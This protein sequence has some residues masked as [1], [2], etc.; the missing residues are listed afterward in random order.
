MINEGVLGKNAYYEDET[1]TTHFIE[2]GDP[3]H[4]TVIILPGVFLPAETYSQFASQL[5]ELDIHVLCINY[6]GR[7]Q[8]IASDK[9]YHSTDNLAAQLIAL[10]RGQKLTK[11]NIVAFSYSV[12]VAVEALRIAPKRFNKL[13]FVSP[14]L[15]PTRK[16][17]Y[18]RNILVSKWKLGEYLLKMSSIHQ[19]PLEVARQM[20][21]PS[22]IPDVYWDVVSTALLQSE[23]NP[24][25]FKA[26][27][28]IIPEFSNISPD[29]N[30]KVL[31]KLPNKGLVIIGS[32]DQT[33]RVQETIDWWSYAMPVVDVQIVEG[34]THLMHLERIQYLL[35]LIIPFLNSQ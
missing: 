25:V 8:S 18:I 35:E 19:I 17:S 21:N 14:L 24:T 32:D 34:A 2:F 7:G 10:I 20:E 23:N 1:G 29:A 31:M 15:F 26:L 9:F 16:P 6:Y 30:L 27:A 12:N 28:Q 3:S 11:V 22:L 5:S 13:I 33:I 4:Q